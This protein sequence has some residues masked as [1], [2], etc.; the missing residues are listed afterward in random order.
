MKT[1]GQAKTNYFEARL[2]DYYAKD[3][4]SGKI[5]L[6]TTPVREFVD[7]INNTF[8][9]YFLLDIRTRSIPKT[10]LSGWTF[11]FKS[12]NYRNDILEIVK[13]DVDVDREIE[14]SLLN[15]FA[16]EKYTLFKVI[17]NINRI[18]PVAVFVNDSIYTFNDLKISF[19]EMFDQSDII[20][21]VVSESPNLYIMKDHEMLKEWLVIAARSEAFKIYFHS[22]VMKSIEAKDLNQH[23][24]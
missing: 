17:Y 14:V 24:D 21:D 9:E 1:A 7:F 10:I 15:T 13:S 5:V 4:V 22:A 19:H 8:G 11:D 20:T 23:Q 3:T 2:G 12:I 16:V 18:Y 6:P